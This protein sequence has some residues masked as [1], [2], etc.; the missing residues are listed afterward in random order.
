MKNETEK[1]SKKI[2]TINEMWNTFKQLIYVLLESCRREEEVQKNI[3]I[4]AKKFS[5]SDENYK[6][7]DLRRHS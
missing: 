5:K 1:K 4:M 7:T 6:P 3:W 2:N